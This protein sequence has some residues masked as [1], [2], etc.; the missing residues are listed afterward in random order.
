MPI[1]T[2]L[3]PKALRAGKVKKLKT[4]KLG[5]VPKPKSL[6]ANSRKKETPIDKLLKGE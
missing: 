5:K 4:P 6:S 3:K 2:G 1:T